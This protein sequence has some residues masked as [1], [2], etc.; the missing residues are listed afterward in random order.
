MF[1]ALDIG[2]SG[3]RAQRVR[4]DTISNNI[5]NISTTHQK[6]GSVGPYKRRF[7]LFAPGGVN[8]SPDAG[9]QVKDVVVD[10]SGEFQERYDPHNPDADDRGI[11]KYPNIDLAT[12]MV[13]ALEAS[14]SYDANI[15]TMETS[16]AMFNSTLR[17]IA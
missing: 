10:E 1:N 17:L 7:V 16:K 15:T 9:V 6:D 2:A 5:A 8:G 13:N 14:R 4:M 3:L 11:V 12:E